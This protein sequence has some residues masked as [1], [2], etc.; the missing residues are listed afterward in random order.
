MCLLLVG[1]PGSGKTTLALQFPKPYIF[2]ADG[3][4]SGPVRYLRQNN[5]FD[6]KYDSGIVDSDDKTVSPFQRWTHMSK[7]LNEAI[8]D[9]EI[10]TIIIDSLSV[11][12]DF[13]KDDI[14]RQRGSNPM[15]KNAPMVN[16]N[17]RSMIPLIQHEW[18]V[19]AQYFVELVTRLKA[20]TTKTIIFTAHFESKTGDDNITRECL[21]IQGRMRGQFAGMFPDVWQTYIK[22]EG[23]GDT[24][25]YQRMVRVVPNNQLDEKGTKTSLINVPPT[26]PADINYILNAIKA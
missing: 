1:T 15:A 3:N 23:M 26:F 11:I 21:C 22:K 5:S 20:A 14:K 24:A 17:N 10:E 4:L 9:P 19:F 18:D 6:F 12:A 25:K 2:D 8:Q 16:E 13:V 7:C